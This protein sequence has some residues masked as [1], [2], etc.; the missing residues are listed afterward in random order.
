MRINHQIR[1]KTVRVIGE[2][3][4]MLGIKTIFDALRLAEEAGLDLVEI[5]PN[6]EPPV[7]KVADYGKLRYDQQKKE[8]D[9]KRSQAQIRV[10]EVKVKP[11]IDIHDLEVKARHARDF[12]S[13]GNKV[14][15]TCTFRGREMVH[16]EIGQRVV[17]GFCKALEDVSTVETP[18]KM[19]GKILSLVLAPAKGKKSPPKPGEPKAQK[20]L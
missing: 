13:K 9:G 11:N 5:A 8:K 12:L 14:R 2:D 17:D 18:S 19:M 15:L 1:A 3:G 4:E 6:V 10:K 20:E 16:Q 7:V